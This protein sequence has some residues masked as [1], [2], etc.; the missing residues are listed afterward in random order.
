[1]S[2]LLTSVLNGLALGVLLFL[3]AVGLSVT[4][5]LMGVLNL[6]HGALVMI[7]V[8]VTYSLV[9]D[10]VGFAP[11]LLIAAAAGCLMGVLISGALR[12]LLRSSELTQA[13]FTLGV[14]FIFVDVVAAVWGTGFHSIPPPA[15][16]DGSF[17]LLGASYPT[18]RLAVL[19]VGALIALA[20]TLAFERSTFGAILRAGV[21]D[22]DMLEMSGVNARRVFTW[23]FVIGT[24]LAFLG[25]ALGAPILNAGPGL[26]HQLLLLSLAI[27]IVGGLG[28][29][30]GALVGAL[31]VGQ[32]QTV[33]VAYAGRLAPFLLFAVMGLFL[34]LKPSGLFG[35]ASAREAH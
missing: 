2:V 18:Y 32:V 33:G 6:A 9:S 31:L 8:Y 7:G 1:M 15:F 26:D 22:R 5:G 13:L 23:A 28:S 27:V 11:A 20:V 14:A 24:A 12:P 4:Y 10:G 35:Y 16:L 19:V 30:R 21:Q 17:P 29:V 25:G 34:V 3:I